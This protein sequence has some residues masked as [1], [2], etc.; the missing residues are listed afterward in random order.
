VIVTNDPRPA[1]G[2][3]PDSALVSPIF[4]HGVLIGFAGTAAHVPDIGSILN[5][6]FPAPVLARHLTGH[7]L[8]IVSRRPRCLCP[9][10]SEDA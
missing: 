5:P 7:L 6:T 4:H 1:T 10:R 8:S 2:H 9:P 3:L